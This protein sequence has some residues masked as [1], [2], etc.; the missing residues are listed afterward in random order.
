MVNFAKYFQIFGKEP[1]HL[2]PFYFWLV[3][4]EDEGLPSLKILSS[5]QIYLLLNKKK[6][7]LL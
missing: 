3:G 2:L 7:N 4:A 6:H 5:L 1:E